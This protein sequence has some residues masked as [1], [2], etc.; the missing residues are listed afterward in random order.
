MYWTDWGVDARIER[1]DMDGNN[2][3]RIVQDNLGWPNGL[4]IDRP[5]ARIIWAD[6]R[7]EVLPSFSLFPLGLLPLLKPSKR[8]YGTS[9]TTLLLKG[10]SSLFSPRVMTPRSVRFS[11][12]D[13]VRGPQRAAP[14]HPRHVRAA[15]VRNDGRR[16]FP[17]LDGLAD[18]LR[19]PRG[20]GYR[21]RPRHGCGE[22]VRPHGHPRRPA[23]ER[24]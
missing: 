19:A 18:S 10:S 20:Q 12:G 6:A 13:R 14:S 5:S 7:T 2:R 11:T 1:A 24:R 23:R 3:V 22:A 9:L 15:P 17:L 21:A 4:T 16:Q 8:L